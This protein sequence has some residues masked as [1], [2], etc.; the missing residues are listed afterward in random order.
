MK[1]NFTKREYR[2][3]LELVA[4]GDW[5]LFTGEF[6]GNPGKKRY[7]DIVQKLY[8]HAGEF[9][10]QDMIEYNKDY[11]EYEESAEF[12]EYLQSEFIDDYEEY[13]LWDGLV[14]K[15]AC[16]DMRRKNKEKQ[17]EQMTSE[18]RIQE[19]ER[20]CALYSEEFNEFGVERIIFDEQLSLERASDVEES[21]T[22]GS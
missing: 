16:R 18:Q 3:L 6:E 21:C 19:F 15:L 9:G 12:E 20:I 5:V 11:E 7:T 2:T 22:E 10:C 13:I 1:I 8:S 17:I 14:F 4:L